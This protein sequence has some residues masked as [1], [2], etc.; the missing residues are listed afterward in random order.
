[1]SENFSLDSWF[2][3]A[4][5]PDSVTMEEFDKYVQEFLIERK[6]KDDIE[7]QLT[8]QNKKVMS[9]QGKLIEFL[10]LMGKTKHVVPEGT[11]SKVETTSWK[12]PEGEFRE[13]A[14]QHLRDIGEY[15][16]VMA[17]NSK[18]FSSWYK[19]A[20]EADPSFHLQGVEQ[21][22]TKYIRFMKAKG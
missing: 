17:F 5:A 11:I 16:S 6:K 9:M 18:K 13:N 21:D 19:E 12:A 22:V 2:E 1:M 8:E 4:A 3:S 10:D 15:D 14:I 7:S 20:I